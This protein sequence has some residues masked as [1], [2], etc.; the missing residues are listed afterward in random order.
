MRSNKT[1]TSNRQM[2]ILDRTTVL[3]HP[4][5]YLH[6]DLAWIIGQESTGSLC[7]TTNQQRQT[8][9]RAHNNKINYHKVTTLPKKQSKIYKGSVAHQIYNMNNQRPLMT[10]QG[11]QYFYQPAVKNLHTRNK[12]TPS[13]SIRRN[14]PDPTYKA[15]YRLPPLEQLAINQADH[16]RSIKQ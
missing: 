10:V 6:E 9:Q 13:K 16:L 8:N 7:V 5:D 3:S 4:N 2:S 14:T 12:L 11:G 15:S 1:S